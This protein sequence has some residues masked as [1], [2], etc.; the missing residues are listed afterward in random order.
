[1]IEMSVS[2]SLRPP[3]NIFPFVQQRKMEEIIIEI[4]FADL[5]NQHLYIPRFQIYLTKIDLVTSSLFTQEIKTVDLFPGSKQ[6]QCLVRPFLNR[7]FDQFL[8]G[9]VHQEQLL[10][11]HLLISGHHVFVLVQRRTRTQIIN[12][13][14]CFDFPPVR[15]A[16][17]KTFRILEPSHPGRYPL[18]RCIRIIISIRVF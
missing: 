11:L 3:N 9:R 4:R 14:K 17:V 12:D 6:P 2:R 18:A 1:M 13:I 5:V 16:H 10:V 7:H 15:A 8:I